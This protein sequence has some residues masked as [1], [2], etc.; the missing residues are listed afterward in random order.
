MGGTTFSVFSERLI[1]TWTGHRRSSAYDHEAVCAEWETAFAGRF[2]REHWSTAGGSP[3]PELTS[4]AFFRVSEAGPGDFIAV[5]AS[6]GIAFGESIFDGTEWSLT[7]RWLRDLDA[8]VVHLRFLDDDTYEQE[9]V[10]LAADGS[11]TVESFAVMKRSPTR[12]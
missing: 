5:Y 6:G 11:P 8:A 3:V 12:S 2:L 7:H 9:V 1:G 10:T 4:E